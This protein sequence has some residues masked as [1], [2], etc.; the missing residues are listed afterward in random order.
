MHHI[1]KVLNMR[2][3]WRS[4][5]LIFLSIMLGGC[6]LLISVDKLKLESNNDLTARNFSSAA[7]SAQ[8]WV[9][10]APDQYEA[11]FVLAQ[12]Q[13]QVGDKNAALVALEQAIKKG[14]RDDMQIEGNTHLDPIKSMTAYHALMSSHFPSRNAM[15]DGV[16]EEPPGDTSADVSVSIT[17][18][19]GQQTLRA[20]DVFIQM[21]A[22][23]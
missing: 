4:T 15:R 19:D 16:R 20:G 22:N 13:A 17:E 5:A 7:Q 3:I 8:K 12:A 21:P 11:Y 23:K 1:F 6:D 9:E 14:L 10:K 2:I 18:K